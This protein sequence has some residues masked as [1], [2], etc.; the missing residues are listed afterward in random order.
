MRFVAEFRDPNG[1]LLDSDLPNGKVKWE[2]AGGTITATGYYVAG[3]SLG[4]YRVKATTV[5]SSSG[6][7]DTTTVRIETATD[8]TATKQQPVATTIS[9]SP[10]SVALLAGDT[11]RFAATVRDQNG[12]PMTAPIAWTAT[13]GTMSGGVYV[14]G[15]SAGSY[16]ATATSGALSASAAVTI[17]LPPP[18]APTP[19]ATTISISP[20][21]VALLAGDTVRFAA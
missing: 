16:K 12:S 5:G 9:I 17:S 13:G 1:N 10:G 6:L 2:T 14:G 19:V 4:A 21:S 11:V 3:S 8:T 7:S 15:S 20:G 18:D